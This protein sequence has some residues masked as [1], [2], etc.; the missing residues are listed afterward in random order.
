MEENA[1]DPS[2]PAKPLVEANVQN[3]LNKSL[4]TPVIYARAYLILSYI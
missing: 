4:E 2:T 3:T 1:P